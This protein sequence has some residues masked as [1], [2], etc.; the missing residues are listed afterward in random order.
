MTAN[1]LQN[2]EMSLRQYRE[3][4]QFWQWCLLEPERK[5][6]GT[7]FSVNDSLKLSNAAWHLAFKAYKSNARADLGLPESLSWTEP[8]EFGGKSR[9]AWARTSPW[10]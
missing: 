1:A 5:T 7:T 3:S 9:Y 6:A 10:W 4:L 2:R 8:N